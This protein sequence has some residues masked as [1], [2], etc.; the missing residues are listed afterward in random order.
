MSSVAYDDAC[1]RCG[2]ENTISASSDTRPFD[3]TSGVCVEC[4]FSYCTKVYISDLE[5]VNSYRDSLGLEPIEKLSEER[6][7]NWEESDWISESKV[8]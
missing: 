3:Q 5:T 7:A 2:G 6:N 4:G 8:A 1:P